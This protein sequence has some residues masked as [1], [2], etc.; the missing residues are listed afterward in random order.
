MKPERRAEN[1]SHEGFMEHETGKK[2]RK[3]C[4]MKDS[5]SMKP[6]RRAEKVSHEG[7]MEHETGKK[8]RKSVA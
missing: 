8:S 7:F 1:V 2:S 4:R 3:K 6:E 5:W